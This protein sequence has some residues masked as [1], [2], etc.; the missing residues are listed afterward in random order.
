MADFKQAVEWM[1]EGKKVRISS[2]PAKNLFV[3]LIDVSPV[4]IFSDGENKVT[5]LAIGLDDIQATDWE[6]YCPEHQWTA[7]KMQGNKVLKKACI[8]CGKIETVE[9]SSGDFLKRLGIDGQIWAKEFIKINKEKDIANEEGTMIG[10]FANAIMAGW[11]ESARRMQ[12]DL[13]ASL[14]KAFAWITVEH[15]PQ[16][17]SSDVASKFKE[18]FGDIL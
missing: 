8:N 2:W 15:A 11:D 16:L 12:K 3:S 5:D 6:I 1:K 18:L 4:F 13:R 14:I 10:W 7:I 17:S 9:E